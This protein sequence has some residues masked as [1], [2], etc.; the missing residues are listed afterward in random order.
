MGVR[1]APLGM[2]LWRIAVVRHLLRRSWF[3]L[4][5]FRCIASP[6]YIDRVCVG[7]FACAE[8]AASYQILLFNI[9]ASW[10]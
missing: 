4:V 5:C 3:D 10:Q 8:R 1:L 6:G 2:M 9:S 7:V